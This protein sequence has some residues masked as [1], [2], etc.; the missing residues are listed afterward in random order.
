M[1]SFESSPADAGVK[2]M[3][4]WRSP[5]GR[6]L[7]QVRLNVNGSRV[8]AY[9]RIVAAA[10]DR[11]AYSASYELVT[12]DSGVAR[13]LSVR[14]LREPGESALDVSRDMDGRWMVQ[15]PTSSVRSHF[16]GAETVS[17]EGSPFFASIPL[18]RFGIVAG[19]RRDDVPVV[20]L[21]LPECE[22]DAASMSYVGGGA[23]RVTVACAGRTDELVVDDDGIVLDYPGVAALL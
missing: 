3:L 11:E 15:T 23:G 14:L 6:R 1:T 22:I 12:T 16:D 17:V 8:R 5:D 9:G 4:T 2:A 21:R 19:G 20:T 13:R 18:R 7:E 10:A